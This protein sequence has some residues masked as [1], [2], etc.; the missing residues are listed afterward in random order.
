MCTNRDRMELS[1]GP[2]Q[3]WS[4]GGL[5]AITLLMPALVQAQSRNRPVLLPPRPVIARAGSDEL[6]LTHPLDGMN[7]PELAAAPIR[8]PEQVQRVPPLPPTG[9]PVNIYPKLTPGSQL[10]SPYDVPRSRPT[11]TQLASQSA[12]PCP[13]CGRIH[14]QPHSEMVATGQP[15]QHAPLPPTGSPVSS[16]AMAAAPAPKPAYRW[17]G[18][19]AASPQTKQPDSKQVTQEWYSATGAT[20]G[21]VPTTPPPAS[22]RPSV[23]MPMQ[24]AQQ[25]HR[26][27]P[28]TEQISR[29]PRP[30]APMLGAPSSIEPPL[31][32]VRAE[33]PISTD[34]PRSRIDAPRME[35]P[36]LY[37]DSAPVPEDPPPLPVKRH[38][39]IPPP[40][41]PSVQWQ[42]PTA[43]G[44]VPTTPANRQPSQ[45]TVS[46]QRTRS[47][48]MPEYRQPSR[49]PGVRLAAPK[50]IARAQSGDGRNTT[51]RRSPSVTDPWE[52][53]RRRIQ[54]QCG[55]YARNISVAPV[56]AGTLKVSFQVARS[57]IAEPLVNRIAQMPELGPY[58]VDFEVQ[59]D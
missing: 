29:P 8:L 39:L 37:R 58:T 2:W 28:S 41:I 7:A 13:Q 51:S 21:A 30:V 11:L 3:A 35:V 26:S 34:P 55:R 50:I 44:I 53:L 38:D 5:L 1:R 52:P 49:R 14:A 6:P 22:T 32:Q 57:S 46:R 54:E 25:P 4:T 12:K 16:H 24:M 33:Q 31:Q 20:A 23:P 47:A 59:I 56:G 10:P 15:V 42:A 27:M 9:Q 43:S 17:Y 18:Y 45:S 48:K 19:G 40:P 36:R